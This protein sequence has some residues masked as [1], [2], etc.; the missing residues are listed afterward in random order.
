MVRTMA[1]HYLVTTATPDRDSAAHLA[2]SA[3]GAKLAATAQVHGP[4]SSFWWH[5]GE[6]GESEEWLATFKTTDSRYPDLEAHILDSHPWT[7]AEVTAIKIEAG[8]AGYL[9]WLER[10]TN[11]AMEG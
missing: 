9:S 7:N 8:A 1:H 3:V 6:Q 11:P 4:V 10:T 2:A 5:L